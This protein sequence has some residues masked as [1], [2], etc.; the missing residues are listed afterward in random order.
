MKT[1]RNIH[2]QASDLL[3]GDLSRSER[4]G[5]RL[6]LMMCRH[7]RR[8]MR[9][10]ELLTSSLGI[11]AQTTVA[12]P[13][14]VDRIIASWQPDPILAPGGLHNAPPPGQPDDSVETPQ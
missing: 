11:H 5:I 14:L 4:M 2:E 6:H 13:A 10:I 8:F 7:C 12:S 9:H 1:C 3:A